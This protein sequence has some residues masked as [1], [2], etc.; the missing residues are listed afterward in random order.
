MNK[1][2]KQTEIKE[3]VTPLSEYTT[4]RKTEFLNFKPDFVDSNLS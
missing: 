2:R 3:Q 4:R 1:N